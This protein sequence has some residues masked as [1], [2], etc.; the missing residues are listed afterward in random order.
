MA[1]RP[2]KNQ[3]N[4]RRNSQ[5]TLTNWGA[6][7]LIETLEPRQ[8][9]SAA[10]PQQVL[11]WTPDTDATAYSSPTST[12][13]PG[14][15]KLETQLVPVDVSDANLFGRAGTDAAAISF[16][17]IF[18]GADGTCAFSAVLS[19][20]ALV[21]GTLAISIEPIT[22]AQ[23]GANPQARAASV[24]GYR[25]KLYKEN[26]SGAY[27]PAFVDVPFDGLVEPEDLQPADDNEF[28]PAIFQRAYLQLAEDLG[29]EFRNS[30]FAMS[31]LTGKATT[32]LPV[33]GKGLVEA[34][35]IQTALN[36]GSFT[37]A[38]SLDAA[39]G[40]VVLLDG[41]YGIVA[42][43]CYTVLGIEIPTNGDLTNT[44]VTVRN[45][46]GR[47]T[48]W[49]Y[50]DQDGNG[51]LNMSEVVDLE[52]G[53]DGWNDGLVRM[54]WSAFATYFEA[55]AISS[56]TGPS[57]NQ[58]LKLNA[59]PVFSPN[60]VGPFTIHEG[61]RLDVDLN[62]TDPDGHGVFYGLGMGSPGDI[63]LQNGVYSW[64]PTANMVG[65]YAI[66]VIAEVSKFESSSLT[67]E[68]N[69]T[70]GAPTIGSLTS[71]VSSIGDGGVDLLTLTANNVALPFVDANESVGPVE[72]W[73]DSDGNGAFNEDVDRFLGYGQ[74]AA[75]RS[76]SGYI[77]SVTPG[78]AK[79]FTRAGWFSA[80][81]LHYSAVLSKSITITSTPVVPPVATP[82]S[83]T[84]ITP[85]TA[86][87][88]QSGFAIEADASGN[89]RTFWL[90]RKFVPVNP[91]NPNLG[92]YQYALHT[93][94]YDSAGSVLGAAQLL[95][96]FPAPTAVYDAEVMP[97]GSFV[98]AWIESV[99]NSIADIKIQRYN[100]AGSPVGSTVTIV[101]DAAW[102][103][104]ATLEIAN[105]S[106]GNLL[107]VYNKGD[108][109][110]EDSMAVSV[111][112]SN[113]VTRAPWVVN[114][115]T[116]SQQKNPAVALNGAGNGVIVWNDGDAGKIKGRVVSNYGQTNGA[117][118][119]VATDSN[120]FDQVIDVAVD[121]SG[122]FIVSWDDNGVRAR[123]FNSS[124]TPL[125][126]AFLVNTN[127]A[128]GRSNG[129]VSISDSG[130]SV[131]YWS[132][133]AQDSGAS[134]GTGAYAQLYD[135]SGTAVGPEIPVAT[136]AKSQ[137]AAAVYIDP[138]A[139]ATFLW[140]EGPNYPDK[141]DV[142]SS[143]RHYEI[144]LAPTFT[145]NPTF[146]IPENSAVD[147]VVGTVTA[148]D[149][150]TPTGLTYSIV[151]GNFDDAFVINSTTG[152]IRVADDE[153]LNFEIEASF[154]LVIR[155]VDPSGKSDLANVTINLTDV[156]EG[157]DLLDLAFFIFENTAP[158]TLVG[159]A[160]TAVDQ[161]ESDVI[162]YSIL[163]GDDASLFTVDSQSGQIFL[164]ATATLNF[165]TK[166]I[167]SFTLKATDDSGKFE[168]ATVFVNLL[169]RIEPPVIVPPSA[170][171]AFS[172]KGGP[173]AL[174][175]NVTLASS[176]GLSDQALRG[177]TLVV[178]INRASKKAKFFDTLSGFDAVSGI[179]QLL[180]QQEV[181][182]RTVFSTKLNDTVT[183]SAVE[184]YLHGLNF[185]TKGPGL[186]LTTRL[187]KVQLIGT[188]GV[189]SN[190]IEQTISIRKK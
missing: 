34:Q 73:Q 182:G 39:E 52:Y 45:P 124:G 172:K 6:R 117:A 85:T 71:N 156:D 37:T 134:G 17:D 33:L 2:G 15:I 153:A 185:S 100:A 104:N 170:P 62:A 113:L 1:K 147:T 58:P 139:D 154:D 128:G 81:D 123:R 190:L 29:K 82:G 164:S 86:G 95:V 43:H 30:V 80:S 150:D 174:L 61:Q 143:I 135:P 18:Q 49:E 145:S 107:L 14:Q 98:I 75:S 42:N 21:P 106:A 57:I 142:T 38:S 92:N 83:A 64:T 99:N 166:P 40:G 159:D 149:S 176:D 47:D 78:S 133:Y 121:A 151:S 118:F 69:V 148:T 141:A 3:R 89:L 25:V 140:W 88:D 126:A 130:W 116:T 180:S 44:F 74:G 91:N 9:L 59:P 144:N 146:G 165:E 120:V 189:T 101:D 22:I 125:G 31:T 13:I 24:P 171:V 48:Y 41:Q 102:A 188:D 54:P 94:L 167:L 122:N 65:K 20:N 111:S 10:G 175:P 181:G 105:D 179:G 96:N 32:R 76:W 160:G 110:D 16:D 90:D 186:K 36:G 103:Q 168:T 8:M 163:P 60:A 162:T 152:Q 19:A 109:F 35:R 87:V 184:D 79:F 5:L 177:A 108:Y 63:N 53:V 155:V 131:I 4:S 132:A 67:F 183:G 56:V 137:V 7:A 27:V 72:F 169:N 161:D 173:A 23:P 158:R 28:W 157:P 97:D 93:R 127:L 46:W 84:L 55:A 178:S 70:T 50:F 26:G 112:S 138:D 12:A 77:G 51:A 187:L 115:S 11:E 114:S 136:G 66:T 119:D 68:V 129:L